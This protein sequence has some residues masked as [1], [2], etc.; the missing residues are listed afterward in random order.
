[1]I[2]DRFILEFFHLHFKEM[3]TPKLVIVSGWPDEKGR[4]E[5][6]IGKYANAILC[7]T[8]K[9]EARTLLHE[10]LIRTGSGPY[11][12]LNEIQSQY[13]GSSCLPD[14]I[15][16][17]FLPRWG[18][19]RSGRY[20]CL[21][22][23]THEEMF[24]YKFSKESCRNFVPTAKHWL[25]KPKPVFGNYL[26]SC[27]MAVTLQT[28]RCGTSRAIESIGCMA[29][30]QCLRKP[31]QAILPIGT[32]T[33]IFQLLSDKDNCFK[34]PKRFVPVKDVI[35]EIEYCYNEWDLL[36]RFM[37]HIYKN[38]T[39]SIY[40]HGLAS[41]DL[42]FFLKRC[43]V[44][45]ISKAM[46][47]KFLAV[48][49]TKTSCY[50]APTMRTMDLAKAFSGR[51]LYDTLL[52]CVE[53]KRNLLNHVSERDPCAIVKKIDSEYVENFA[54]FDSF[55]EEETNWF[56]LYKTLSCTFYIDTYFQWTKHIATIRL[57]SGCPDNIIALGSAK[58][59]IAK[60]EMLSTLWK[61]NIKK[62]SPINFTLQEINADRRKFMS[63]TVG[64]EGG[65]VIDPVPGAYGDGVVIVLDVSSHYPKAME[66]LGRR[67]K[68]KFKKLMG[69]IATN[70]LRH[71]QT[72]K[73]KLAKTFDPITKDTL[74][75]R[76]NATK[77]IQNSHYGVLGLPSYEYYAPVYASTVT[78]IGRQR[79]RAI[80]C[81]L[82]NFIEKGAIDESIRVVYGDTDSI[83]VHVPKTSPT[84]S[85]LDV[86]MRVVRI[87][88]MMSHKIR[89]TMEGT[90]LKVD[91]M[92]N[93][94][95]LTNK[96]K[97]YFG[98]DI[99]GALHKSISRLFTIGIKGAKFED[100]PTEFPMAN[101]KTF[102]RFLKRI[103][104]LT[105]EFKTNGTQAYDPEEVYHYFKGV[106]CRRGDTVSFVSR[107]QRKLA[108]EVMQRCLN[109][110]KGKREKVTLQDFIKGLYRENLRMQ[111][112]VE[113]YII[114]R[115]LKKKLSEYKTS[116]AHV[117]VARKMYMKTG[118][119]PA[120]RESV[121]Y[122]ICDPGTSEKAKRSISARAKHPSEVKS[123]FEIDI[124]YYHGE[125]MSALN[126]ILFPAIV[127]NQKRLKRILPDYQTAKS[128]ELL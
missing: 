9:K 100:G 59:Q 98:I 70:L 57:L 49:P 90:I 33:K 7:T 37:L 5:I 1:M 53:M 41:R 101:D 52:T 111:L 17:K 115:Q 8:E 118:L 63:K 81:H 121:P 80:M 104:D 6:G 32:R 51:I 28:I 120:F 127:S 22:G 45:G 29:R 48:V 79:L 73:D 93:P 64:Y 25:Q 128:K 113:D 72:I 94:L 38:K 109:K 71:R 44:C 85:L 16:I 124:A 89:T 24:V 87:N 60:H 92:F 15:D 116:L 102:K 34:K 112:S 39:L 4:L 106:K 107:L 125:L 43:N 11:T 27:A 88:A 61:N 69:Y 20:Y 126:Q 67:T 18:V 12:S 65:L 21:Y 123:V 75:S 117:Q 62:D 50:Y 86:I 114:R 26:V 30:L 82:R 84:E 77:A 76:D 58:S 105:D 99:F 36:Q 19:P 31:D 23:N 68:N 2:I 110:E 14:K 3:Q 47:D 10:V 95:I 103:E 56:T 13:D 119:I 78:K 66:L 83:F 96:K 42:K 46:V 74:R 55:D 54:Y 35:I 108:I 91:A 122:I 97:Q 40:W